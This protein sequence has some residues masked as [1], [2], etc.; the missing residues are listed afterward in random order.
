MILS[1]VS[2]GGGIIPKMNSMIPHLTS[3]VVDL[4]KI[5]VP[6]LLIIFGMLDLGKAV[7]AS[8]EDEIK[9]AQK[10]LIKRAIYAVAIF[11]VVFIVQVVFRLIDN[12]GDL[13]QSN[14]ITCWNTK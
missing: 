11:F 10:L 2:C 13:G 5:G 1:Y 9:S 12:S 8:K 6:V 7:M 3:L 4:I 14:W